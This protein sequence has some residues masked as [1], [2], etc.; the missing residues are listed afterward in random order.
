MV[1]CGSLRRWSPVWQRWLKNMVLPQL[2]SR[3]Q[4]GSDSIPGPGTSIC[5]E[6][7]QKT[8]QNKTKIKQSSPPTYWLVTK[9]K[10]VTL[11]NPNRYHLNQWSRVISK[12]VSYHTP[13]YMMDYWEGHTLLWHQQK[14]I[15]LISPGEKTSDKTQLRDSLQNKL[16]GLFKS[17]K[18][19]KDKKRLR[20]CR[21][22]EETQ[23]P[24]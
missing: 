23:E 17:V 24:C 11:E 20:S 2:Q 5:C 22:L 14:R 18:D 21:R 7:S 1:Q 9:G 10:V 16:P 4:L 13:P 19:L 6:C 15:T 12:A 8:K 3:S